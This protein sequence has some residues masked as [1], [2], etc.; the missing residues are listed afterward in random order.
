MPS[1]VNYHIKP[2]ADSNNAKKLKTNTTNKKNYLF[3]SI[4]LSIFK[5]MPESRSTVEKNFHSQLS[6]MEK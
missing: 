5:G 1:L 3:T 6:K 4:I 2:F